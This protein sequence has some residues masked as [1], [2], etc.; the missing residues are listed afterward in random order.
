MVTGAKGCEHYVGKIIVP[1]HLW[2]V[3]IQIRSCHKTEGRIRIRNGNTENN[4]QNTAQ[5]LLYK[6]ALLTV[7][8]YGT[9]A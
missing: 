8:T 7:S 5:C 3:V 9:V 1:W 4:F 2:N 6:G